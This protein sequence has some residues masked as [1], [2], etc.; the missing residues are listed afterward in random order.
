MKIKQIKI[1]VTTDKD[2]F[3]S[4]H[5]YSMGVSSLSW[6]LRKR[7]SNDMDRIWKKIWDEYEIYELNNFSHTLQRLDLGWL[8]G[9][10]HLRGF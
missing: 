10:G 9:T 4:T 7:V 3:A 5:K 1:I 6:K 8:E 2:E